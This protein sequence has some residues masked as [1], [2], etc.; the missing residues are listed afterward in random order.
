MHKLFDTLSALGLGYDIVGVSILAWGIFWAS[1]RELRY[2]SQ[3]EWDLSG[4]VYRAL[5]LQRRD[6][7]FGLALAIIGFVF[8]W[9]GQAYSGSLPHWTAAS[10]WAL[11]V[12]MTIIYLSVRVRGVDDEVRRALADVENESKRNL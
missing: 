11:L 4:K 10:L 7:R 3:W 8:Q 1:A 12:V 9:A 5:L 2:Q 6:V